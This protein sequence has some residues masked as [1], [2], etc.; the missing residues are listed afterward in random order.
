MASRGANYRG[1]DREREMKMTFDIHPAVCAAVREHA[2]RLDWTQNHLAQDAFVRLM[3]MEGYV[4]PIP[5]DKVFGAVVKG[6]DCLDTN[7][8]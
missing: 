6:Q 2:K 4:L 3:G 5:D 7:H 8:E 1:N